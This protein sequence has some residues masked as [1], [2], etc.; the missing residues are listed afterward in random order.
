[1]FTYFFTSVAEHM[2]YTL[3][4]RLCAVSVLSQVLVTT[5]EVILKDALLAGIE[6]LTSDEREWFHLR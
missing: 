5:F 4:S 3:L 1:M 2:K 6:V